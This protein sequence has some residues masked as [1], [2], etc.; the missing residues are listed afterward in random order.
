MSHVPVGPQAMLVQAV[1]ELGS[2]LKEQAAATQ[3]QVMA[4]LAPLQMSAMKPAGSTPPQI[5]CFRCGGHGHILRG[6]T[7]SQVWCC[8]CKTNSHSNMACCRNQK[9]GNRQ[10]SA[11]GRRATTQTEAPTSAA[12]PA[13]Q[14]VA[15]NFDPRPQEASAWTWQPQ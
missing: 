6:C 9:L 4:A 14:G 1:K 2:A 15:A 11:R 10:L 13:Q 3:S 8:F 12:F 7:V 5:K